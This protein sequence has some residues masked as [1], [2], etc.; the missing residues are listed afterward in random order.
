M[1]FDKKFQT[2]TVSCEGAIFPPGV[3]P[4]EADAEPIA[5]TEFTWSASAFHRIPIDG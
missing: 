3:D 1:E 5:G 4:F 2:V